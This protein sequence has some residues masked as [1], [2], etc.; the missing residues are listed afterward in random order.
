MNETY[1]RFGHPNPKL[2]IWIESAKA[3]P[4]G[5][6]L[7]YWHL[8]RLSLETQEVAV[9]YDCN[10]PKQLPRDVT[11]I[12]AGKTICKQMTDASF[13]KYKYCKLLGRPIWLI[14]SFEYN[15]VSAA[16]SYEINRT[17]YLAAESAGLL[18]K[19]NLQIPIYEHFLQR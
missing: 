17:I 2:I 19:V 8:Q 12:I 7:L 6:S 5:E 18:P 4:R 10:A 3:S 11:H 13:V 9:D 16:I 15:L 14:H 1:T